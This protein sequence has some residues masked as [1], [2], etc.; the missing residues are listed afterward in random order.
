MNARRAVIVVVGGLTLLASAIYMFLYLYR[1]E[2]NRAVISGVLFL[3]AEVG[4]TGFVV[5]SRVRELHDRLDAPAR[6]QRI[7]AHLRA[8]QGEPSQVF[9]WLKPDGSRSNVFVPILMGAGL[10]LS[11]LAWV[12][13]R[14]GRAT[15]GATADSSVSAHLARLG[16]PAG[17]F[18]DD[19]ADPLRGLRAPAGAPR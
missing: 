14:I 7:S 4:V 2:W 1:W 17:G 9:A 13:E 12:V 18:L 16:P 8:A 10:I 3:A 5:T 11:G 6:R 19:G 15:A